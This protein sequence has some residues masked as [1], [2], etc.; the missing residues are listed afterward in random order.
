M[1]KPIEKTQRRPL[2]H[3]PSDALDAFCHYDASHHSWL[4]FDHSLSHQL[5]ALEYDNRRYIRLP[6]ENKRRSLGF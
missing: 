1:L 2:V 4:K 5:I 6:T 3:H